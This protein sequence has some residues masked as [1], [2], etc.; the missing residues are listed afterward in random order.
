MPDHI[1]VLLSEL[2]AGLKVQ[3]NKDYVDCT[4]G[5]GGH[6]KEVLR[7]NGPEGKLYGID[8]DPRALTLAAGHLEEFTDRVIYINE[9]FRS[10]EEII[11]KNKIKTKILGGI[12]IDLGLSSMQL[13][14]TDGFSFKGDAE[15]NMSF[16]ATSSL[17]AAEIINN[18]SEEEI[19][20]I[21][22]DYG[23]ERNWRLITQAI[24]ETRKEN[25]I[26]HTTQLVEIITSVK[27]RRKK[28]K[29]HP[30]TK[31]WQA[32]RIAV[33]DELNN[34]QDFLP[35]AVK[36]LPSRG[37]LAVIAYHS[38]EDRIVKNYFRQQAKDCI[39]PPEF[40]ECI[41]QHQQTV[42]LI[43]KKPIKPSNEEIITNPR[44]RSARLRII[45]KI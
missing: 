40:P 6:A 1:P 42:K 13:A 5:A 35:Q 45:E 3:P 43:T 33:N 7:L 28:D 12:Y 31:T 34:V 2:I 15:L 37:R 24:V 11:N 23:E 19:G 21:I 20:K 22:R 44:S 39:C 8:A 38:L 30:A 14:S 17:T 4:L 41:C 32:F 9:N 27:R 25:P 16:G 36:A 18:W 26:T 10:L 29:I